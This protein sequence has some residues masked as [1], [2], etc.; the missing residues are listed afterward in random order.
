MLVYGMA[1]IVSDEQSIVS[2]SWVLAGFFVL[3]VSFVA[4]MFA[5][6]REEQNS[7]HVCDPI[8]YIETID[9][10]CRKQTKMKTSLQ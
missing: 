6:S 10:V 8:G 2:L 7:D 3:S 5:D 4:V 1:C 9:I